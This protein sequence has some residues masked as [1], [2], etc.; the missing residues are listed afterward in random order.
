MQGSGGTDFRPVF[1]YVDELQRAGHLRDLRGLLY[2]T[3]GEGIFPASP[4]AYRCAFVFVDDAG[5]KDRVPPWAMRVLLGS[6]EII[7]MGR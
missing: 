1:A 4:P 7:E 3:D 6:D 5:A 2:F